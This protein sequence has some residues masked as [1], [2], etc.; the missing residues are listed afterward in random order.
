MTD[1][2]SGLPPRVTAV[3]LAYGA[4]PQLEACVESLLASEAVD[5]DVIV[6]D[7][8]ASPAA[9]SAIHAMP[10]VR[11][12]SP[13]SNTGFAG[14]CN[15]AAH[16]PGAPILAF[17]N[18][19]VVVDKG[20]IAALADAL[21]DPNVGLVCASVRLADNPEVVNA[22]GNPV[23]FLY[24]SWA[25]GFGDPATSHTEPGPVASVTGAA[26]A[27]RR[28]FWEELG[29]FDERYFV[30]QEDVDLSMRTW[31]AGKQ[32][33]FEPGAIATHHYEFGRTDTKFYYLER[34]RLINL[35]TLPE[36]RTLVR[37]AP[38]A[39]GVEVA[40]IAA[41]TRGG[42]VRQKMAGYRW[43]AA[44]RN[45]IRSRRRAIQSARVRSDADMAQVISA[46]MDIP[47]GFGM[48]P[49]KSADEVLARGWKA[50]SRPRR[51]GS[52]R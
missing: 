23:H 46:H 22:V 1:D 33:R 12:L 38:L 31:L 3:V 25:G 16:K 47:A 42:W 44:N 28:N 35:L 11:V 40:L 8:L 10:S 45:Y 36:R 26:F 50:A 9:I 27:V 6:V 51:S 15:L 30:Y 14:G 34:N 20:C 43:L 21:Q 32:V 29:G 41:A 13:G 7:N 37:V 52:G 39:L 49:P 5:L 48:T 17:I 2:P 19:D 18:S 24:F 4:E